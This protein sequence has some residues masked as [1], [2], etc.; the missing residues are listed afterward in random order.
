MDVHFSASD[1][2]AVLFPWHPRIGIALQQKG[3][4]N[5]AIK[6][7]TD[8]IRLDPKDA[9]AFNDRGALLDSKVDFD[10]AVMD[11]IRR[12]LQKSSYYMTRGY[13]R[14]N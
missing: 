2:S 10:A 1:F 11:Y 6:D 14:L 7:Y 8:A 13:L 3:D 4:V 12:D 5:A 9:I